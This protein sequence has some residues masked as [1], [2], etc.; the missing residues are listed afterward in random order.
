MEKEYK[1]IE[2]MFSTVMTKPGPSAAKNT[3]KIKSD[4]K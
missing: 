4:L 2:R 3:Y 1:W